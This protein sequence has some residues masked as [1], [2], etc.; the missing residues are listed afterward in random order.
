[1]WV[2]N[3]L[4]KGF[5][6]SFFHNFFCT[7]NEF[8]ILD[9]HKLETRQA[10]NG[11]RVVEYIP[12]ILSVCQYS[13]RKTIFGLVSGKTRQVYNGPRVVKFYAAIRIT[14]KHVYNCDIIRITP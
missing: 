9:N 12:A 5:K 13:L 14:A 6:S 4:R 11:T 7:L 2:K 3:P 1:M 8:E 10:Y